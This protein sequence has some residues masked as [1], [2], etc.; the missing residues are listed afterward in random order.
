[1]QLQS[2][3]LPLKKD[4]H[5]KYTIFVKPHTFELQISYVNQKIDAAVSCQM[6]SLMKPAKSDR[7][8]N[9]SNALFLQE[10]CEVKIQI[11]PL[12]EYTTIEHAL[13]AVMKKNGYPSTTVH[14]GLFMA[15][16]T[17]IL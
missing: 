6:P 7:S 11:T 3:N 15:L 16:Y 13:A 2:I 4:V 12:V 5:L 14:Y 9:F 17:Y 10:R 8:R 1:M